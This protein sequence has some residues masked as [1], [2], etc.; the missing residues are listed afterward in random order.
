VKTLRAGVVVLAAAG[1]LLPVALAAPPAPACG[2]PGKPACPLQQ[3]MRSEVAAPLATGELE[4]LAQNLERVGAMNPEPAKWA[5]W[6]AI[7]REG[8]NAA[9]NRN[10]EGARSACARCHKVYRRGYNARYR[11]RSLPE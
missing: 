6:T 5:N 3:W 11:E 8:A 1:L 9:R 7:A 4:R 2:A 10:A